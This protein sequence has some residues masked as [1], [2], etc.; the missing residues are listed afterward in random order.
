MSVWILENGSINRVRIFPPT[1]LGRPTA[2]GTVLPMR[3]ATL[4]VF[5]I[6]VLPG[7]AA[8]QTLYVDEQF[9]FDLTT[10]V[11]F[12]SKPA[13][14]PLANMDLHLELYQRRDP[15]S[16]SS[17]AAGSFRAIASTRG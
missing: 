17:T 5:A 8:A 4:L 7:F 16:S 12:A 15:R 14:S 13:G 10:G 6:L 9:G 3:K 11:V 2:D 1:P